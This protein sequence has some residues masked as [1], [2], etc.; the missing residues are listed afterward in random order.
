MMRDDNPIIIF[1]PHIA[2]EPMAFGDCAC[3][4]SQTALQHLEPSQYFNPAAAY[5]CAP[6]LYHLPLDEEYTVVF[7]LFSDTP[8]AVL[9]KAALAVLNAFVPS[10]KTA[11]GGHISIEAMRTLVELGF[12]RLVNNISYTPASPTTLVAWLHINDKCNLTC[13]Y[14]YLPKSG[15]TMSAQI[16]EAAIKAVFRSAQY[17]GFRSVKVKYAGGEATLNF[18]R[19][20]GIQDRAVE[21]ARATGISLECVVL[22]NGVSLG[23]RMIAELKSRE[24]P[25]MI[26]LD[27]I[28]PVNDAQR[29]F[30]DG[31]GSFVRVARTIDQL[32]AAGHPPQISITITDRNITGLVET[33]EWILDRDLRFSLNFYRETDASAS[34]QD[35][36]LS[37]SRLIEEMSRA[38]AAIERRLPHFSLLSSLLD[39]VHFVGPH[40]HACG[41]GHNYIVISPDGSMAQCQMHMRQT[42]ADV[43]MDDPL[44]PVRSDTSWLNNLPIEE[45]S[46]CRDCNWR[47][48][49]AGGCPFETFRA[50]GR[51]DVKSPYCRVYQTLLPEVMRLEGLR[52]LRTGS[53]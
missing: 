14:C 46:G 33:L 23:S 7:D 45:K 29:T 9:N 41:A 53:T 34:F 51:W 19:I 40:K 32:I 5:T 21:L 26:S 2:H 4:D 36:R 11:S 10:R 16:G 47:Y 49:C 44:L 8:T 38:Y 6:G 12:L 17:H 48:W 20:L 22:T 31:H 50:T 28:G 30:A 1:E 39:R 35:L 3:A 13:D 15:E 27:G 25:I 43:F 18:Q 37:E 42:V 24:M 52:L